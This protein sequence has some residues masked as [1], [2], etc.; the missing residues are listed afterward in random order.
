MSVFSEYVINSQWERKQ[1]GVAAPLSI[2]SLAFLRNHEILTTLLKVLSCI[3]YWDK[4]WNLSGYV[5]FWKTF[6]VLGTAVEQINRITCFLII[7]QKAMARRTFDNL[8]RSRWGLS[9]FPLDFHIPSS[10]STCVCFFFFFVFFLFK[11]IFC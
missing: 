6:K 4:N 5:P 7:L 8:A 10:W 9:C 2:N 1:N 11:H 3:I